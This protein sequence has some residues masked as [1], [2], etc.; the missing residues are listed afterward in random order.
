MRGALRRAPAGPSPQ[1]R[2]SSPSLVSHPRRSLE[3]HRTSN[4]ILATEPGA[5]GHPQALRVTRANTK[6][7]LEVETRADGRNVHAQ[8]STSRASPRMQNSEAWVGAS[9][10]ET[11]V[12]AVGG[13]RSPIRSAPQQVAGSRAQEVVAR[14]KRLT[15]SPAAP[16][17]R[18]WA[19]A[20]ASTGLVDA[21]R[22]APVWS[23]PGLARG[24]E[25]PH[26]PVRLEASGSSPMLR[27]KQSGLAGSSKAVAARQAPERASSAKGVPVAGPVPPSHRVVAPAGSNAAS[28]SRLE[29]QR[30]QDQHHLRTTNNEPSTRASI[31]HG[32]AARKQS[33]KLANGD[34]ANNATEKL[35]AVKYECHQMEQVL[36]QRLADLDI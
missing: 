3:H 34:V 30:A 6:G 27:T 32:V 18:S 17:K 15:S 29:A 5:D 24:F 31:G 10:V 23:P 14:S 20:S 21:P 9:S 22:K 12:Q 11:R 4:E 7:A 36:V 13:G 26:K 16:P 19:N 25:I 35:D 33:A 28:H 8:A 2:P 1:P